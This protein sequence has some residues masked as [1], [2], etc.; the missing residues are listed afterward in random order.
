V[1][2]T[3]PKI[4]VFVLMPFDEEFDDIYEFGIKKACENAGA[5]AERV[6]KQVFEERILERIYNQ[7]AK[8]DIVVAD[9]TGRNSN[10]FYETGYAHALGKRV[11]LLAQSIDDIPFD[12]KD[13][14][15]I[16]YEKRIV[17]LMPELEK[18]VRW[19]IENPTKKEVNIG[20]RIEFYVGGKSITENPIIKLIRAEHRAAFELK[21]DA[22]NL[23]DKRINTVNFQIGFITSRSIEDFYVGHLNKG[24]FEGTG[25]NT[26]ILPN[27]KFLHLINGSFSILPGSWESFSVMFIA[28]DKRPWSVGDEEEIILR[29]FSSEEP[30]DYPFKVQFVSKI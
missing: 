8:A 30:R 1:E 18:R 10:V 16:I 11:I 19:L 29:M 7:I 17:N 5:Y 3:R 12:L 4:F 27:D 14:P 2:D 20:H 9:M 15:H 23:I 28:R 21:I 24:L 25:K 26:V 6:D 22:H 13:Y